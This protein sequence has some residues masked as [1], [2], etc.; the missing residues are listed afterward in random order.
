MFLGLRLIHHWL[1]QR[2]LDALPPYM[3]ASE[4]R[5]LWSE[6][7]SAFGHAGIPVKPAGPAEGEEFWEVFVDQVDQ[8]LARLESP[9]P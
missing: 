3:L 8:V 7:D 4:A 2:D 1:W 9:L 5:L 6:I